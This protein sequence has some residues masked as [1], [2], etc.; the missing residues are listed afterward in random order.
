MSKDLAFNENANIA[1]DL[2]EANENVPLAFTEENNVELFG[3]E[4]A[5][6]KEMVGGLD[7]TLADRE[8]LKN[9][10]IDVIELD[11][12]SENLAIFKELRL[13]LVKNRTS[14]E[15]WHKNNKAFYLAGG[16]FVDAIKNKEIEV[17]KEMESKLLEGEKFFENQEKEK[18]R[19][20]NE[21]RIEKLRPYIEDVTGL[22]FSEFDDE[23]F[24]DY[25]LGKKTRFENEAKAKKESEAKAE[26]ERLAEIERQKAIEVENAK[27]K[28][29]AEAKEKALEKERAEA[30]EKQDAIELKAK[31]EREKAEAERKIEADKQKAIQDKKDAEIKRLKDEKEKSENER[32]AKEKAQKLESEKLAKAPVKKQLSVWVNSFELPNTEVENELSKEIRDKFEAF[33]KWSLTQ[34]NNL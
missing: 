27:L 19:L 17:N 5:K 18:A 31:Q 14:I 15:T 28:A 13:K 32:I 21:S 29:E 22:N 4:P 1:W 8:V 23:S 24:D 12:T 34:I 6:A 25:V 20:L 7:S 11:I 9:A 3:I 30:K 2:H 10:Y 33:K 16:R 26:S